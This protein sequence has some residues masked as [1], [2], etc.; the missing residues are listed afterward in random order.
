MSD[1]NAPMVSVIMATRNALPYLP[2]ALDSIAAQTFQDYEV[3]VVD[4]ESSDDT[5]KV[6]Q[7]YPKTRCIPQ[8]GTGFALAWNDGIKVA[9]GE[10]IAFLD[11]DDIWLPT[12]LQQQV[13]C[14]TGQPETECVVGRVEFFREPGQERPL[15]FKDSLLKGSHVAY[16]PGTSMTRRGVFEQMGR[17][18]SRWKIAA[19]LVWFAD[20]RRSNLPIAVLETT[21]LRKRV[22]GNNLSY[23]TSWSTYQTEIFQH[24]REVLA[25]RRRQ[26][27]KV[28]P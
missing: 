17:F 21:L 28:R 22:H 27:A 23:S 8:A 4:A 20:L 6:A 25:R 18:E 3:I 13:D 11:S 16:M 15:G 2:E 24:I 12:K 10:F 26:Q 14:F 5:I 1:D 7:S 9:R 19:D